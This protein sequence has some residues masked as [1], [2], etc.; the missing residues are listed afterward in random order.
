MR[1]ELTARCA[2]AVM[3]K[4]PVAGRVKTRLSPPLSPEGSMRMSA[5]FLRDITENIALAARRVAVDPWVA[6][7][8][9]GDERLFDGLLAYGTQLLL[10]DG[11][12]PMPAAVERF[13]RSLWQATDRLLKLGYGAACVLNADSPTLPTT[14]LVSLAE[15]LAAPGSRAVLGPA[16]DGG[17]YALGLTRAYPEMFADIDWSTER[18]AEQTRD[19]ARELGLELVELPVWYD[20]DDRIA[21]ARLLG[22]LAE[23]VRASRELAPFNAPATRACAAALGVADLLARAA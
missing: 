8:P 3:A 1:H 2:I 21:L 12:G 11:N 6:F 5:A 18:V 22:D 20:V 16:E 13:G 4:A 23:P 9:A 19:R 15:A 7:T 14:V 10:A 17:Y